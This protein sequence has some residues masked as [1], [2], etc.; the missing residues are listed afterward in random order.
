MDKIFCENEMAFFEHLSGDRNPLHRQSQYAHRTQ[1]GQIVVYGMYA[2][3][4]GIGQW[5]KGRKCQLKK[6]KG[7][8]RKPLVLNECYVLEFVEAASNVEIIYKKSGSICLKVKIFFTFEENFPLPLTN[9]KFTHDKLKQNATELSIQN[10]EIF[11]I[12]E[13]FTYSA[14]WEAFQ[15]CPINFLL[16]KHQLPTV[17]WN[18]LLWS[19]YY[20]GMENPGKQAL[21][22]SFDVTFEKEIEQNEVVFIENITIKPVPRF[23]KIIILAKSKGVSAIQLE[24]FHRPLIID[25]SITQVRSIIGRNNIFSSETVL[26]TGASRGFGAVLAKAFA[27]C[28][29][30]VLLNFNHSK[31]EAEFIAAEIK[32]QGLLCTILQ[33]DATSAEAWQKIK[34]KL[35][36]DGI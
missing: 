31:D 8:F 32:S 28:G 1:F 27:L 15:S 7:E 4:F 20:V 10:E 2:T 29:A 14:N 35:I 5:L 36:N 12:D 34:K 23:N 13:P 17:Q 24:T 18:S 6:I 26:I 21:F 19:T 9:E 3:L 33:G 25:W 11:T 30:H 16:M 22:L